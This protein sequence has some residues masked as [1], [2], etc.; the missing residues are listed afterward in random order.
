MSSGRFW[1]SPSIVTMMPAARPADAGVHRGVLAEVPLEANG[2][3]ARIRGVEPSSMAKVPS[4]EP[5]S[6]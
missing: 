1:R 2:V 3:H 4:V 5:S 6:T